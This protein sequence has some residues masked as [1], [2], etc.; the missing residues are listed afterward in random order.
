VFERGTEADRCNFYKR[1]YESMCPAD[2]V[3]M[4]ALLFF[5]WFSHAERVR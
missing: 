1:A 4:A 2:W 5:R 3:G